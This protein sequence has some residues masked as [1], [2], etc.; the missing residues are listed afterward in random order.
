MSEPQMS[1]L[2]TGGINPTDEQIERLMAHAGDGPVQMI[3]LLKFKDQAE[4]P[5]GTDDL[6]GTGFEAYQRYGLATIPMVE[7]AGGRVVVLQDVNSVVLGD[8]AHDDWDQVAIIE[9]PN[10]AAFLAMVTDPAYQPGTVHR[11]AGLE[12]SVIIATTPLMDSTL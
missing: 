7:A 5:E 1:G 11:T 3:N 10:R 4:Y 12:R 6:G 9:Y 8:M 2:T